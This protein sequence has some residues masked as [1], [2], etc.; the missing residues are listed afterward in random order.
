MGGEEGTALS[1]GLEEPGAEEL[2]PG[3]EELEPEEPGPEEA[4]EAEPEGAE[5]RGL[6]PPEVVLACTSLPP[7]GK[8]PTLALQGGPRR[9]PPPPK[10]RS[11]P[12]RKNKMKY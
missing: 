5:E 12:V 9:V 10:D 2:E 11:A 7:A 1:S 8:C 4:E 6:A 3:L